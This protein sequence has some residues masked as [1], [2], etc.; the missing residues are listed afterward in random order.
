[1]KRAKRV[2]ETRPDTAC[3]PLRV[4]ASAAAGAAPCSLPHS[5]SPMPACSCSVLPSNR[6]T[7]TQLWE[8]VQAESTLTAA[9]ALL[10]HYFI[11]ISLSLV[12]FRRRCASIRWHVSLSPLAT[13]NL[14]LFW[15]ES[16][17]LPHTQTG[18]REREFCCFQFHC[19]PR[20]THRKSH[21]HTHDKLRA[22]LLRVL[23]TCINL[24]SLSYLHR[25]SL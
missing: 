17:N 2:V 13:K 16:T 8:L 24:L 7:H 21:T 19:F 12:F 11:M 4:P 20:C 18:E 1:M 25:K 6:H 22:G 15:V 5:H 3:L 10:R 23:C 14:S 9:P